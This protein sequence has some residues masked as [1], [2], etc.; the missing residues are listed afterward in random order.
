MRVTRTVPVV[1]RNDGSDGKNGARG[2]QAVV[3]QRAT[4][5]VERYSHHVLPSAAFTGHSRYGSNQRNEYTS[6]V[7]ERCR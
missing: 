1:Q 2:E 5:R 7:L 6:A 4:R 3:S